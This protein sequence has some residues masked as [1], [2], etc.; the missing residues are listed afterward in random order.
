[1]S[2]A[3]MNHEQAIQ[4]LQAEYSERGYRTIINAAEKPRIPDL[5]LLSSQGD[6]LWIE[7]EQ[8]RNLRDKKMRQRFKEI[9]TDLSLVHGTLRVYYLA[10][11]KNGD[12]TIKGEKFTKLGH[13][14]LKSVERNI[15]G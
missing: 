10:L 14:A 15:F 4:L 5:L 8:K 9:R 11:P 3:A 7:V 2:S 1:M 6:V 12:K 13:K